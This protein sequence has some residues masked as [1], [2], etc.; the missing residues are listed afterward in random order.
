MALRI[1]SIRSDSRDL[2]QRRPTEPPP[3]PPRSVGGLGAV[4]GLERLPH[5]INKSPA[6]PQRTVVR[7]A[8]FKQP[9]HHHQVGEHEVHRLKISHSE[10]D[11]DLGGAAPQTQHFDAPYG[12]GG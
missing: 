2:F 12:G 6:T 7:V 5:E 10:E 11:T 9:H 3:P 4:K 8:P 1:K